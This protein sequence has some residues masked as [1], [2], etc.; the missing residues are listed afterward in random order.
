MITFTTLRA[1][2]HYLRIFLVHVLCS[3]L[4]SRYSRY[5]KSCSHDTNR[6]MLSCDRCVATLTAATVDHGM[7]ASKDENVCGFLTHC[8]LPC[9]HMQIHQTLV[10]L[11]AL[12]TVARPARA[13]WHVCEMR[14]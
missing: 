9:M 13:D 10:L 8:S 7:F 6:L 2:F 3:A 11:F 14:I 5:E 1:F 4:P 12:K